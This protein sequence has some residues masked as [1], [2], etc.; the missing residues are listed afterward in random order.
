MRTRQTS[1]VI[2]ES[3]DCE[4]I[5]FLSLLIWIRYNIEYLDWPVRMSK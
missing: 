1:L 5:V 2:S 4:P 3:T